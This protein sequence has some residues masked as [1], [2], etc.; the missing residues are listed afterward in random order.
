VVE[1]LQA[2]GWGPCLYV[3]SSRSPM[4][5]AAP[6]LRRAR[7]AALG[8]VVGATIMARGRLLVLIVSLMLTGIAFVVGH[9][10][11]R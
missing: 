7:L 8:A 5:V 6:Y 1:Q 3:E 2:D 4:D 10:L 9:S 11:V